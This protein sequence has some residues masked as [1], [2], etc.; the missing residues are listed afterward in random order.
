MHDINDEK[1]LDLLRKHAINVH[2]PMIHE[3]M[4][5]DKLMEILTD[6]HD[7]WKIVWESI[8]SD[9]TFDM[10]YA[11]NLK[12]DAFLY[13]NDVYELR[14]GVWQEPDADVLEWLLENPPFDVCVKIVDLY[15][16]SRGLSAGASPWLLFQYITGMAVTSQGMGLTSLMGIGGS[17]GI[18]LGRALEA[19]GEYTDVIEPYT[20]LIIEHGGEEG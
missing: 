4:A 3:P 16:Y 1:F 13:N 7:D 12:Y 19:W 18:M 2:G 15:I 9:S 10:L 17:D 11:L 8:P 20:D 6:M 14:G 5:C